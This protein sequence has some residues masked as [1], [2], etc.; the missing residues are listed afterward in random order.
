MKPV[1]VNWAY[2]GLAFIALNK[3]LGVVHMLEIVNFYITIPHF[4][5]YTPSSDDNRHIP[6]FSSFV[7]VVVTVAA[8]G[9]RKRTSWARMVTFSILSVEGFLILGTVLLMLTYDV[10]IYM[11][12]DSQI[13]LALIVGIPLLFLA[14]KIYTSNPLKIY[15]SKPQP[16]SR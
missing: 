5:I 4:D 8:L 12:G 2:I 10:R 9:L 7:L 6:V 16:S 11:D 1:V 14:Y 13:I 3:I 15:L